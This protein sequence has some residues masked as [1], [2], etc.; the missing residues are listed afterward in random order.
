MCNKDIRP[1]WV[2]SAYR[3]VKGGIKMPVVKIAL[4]SV[5]SIYSKQGFRRKFIK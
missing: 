2:P 5:K 4:Y 1:E 3:D